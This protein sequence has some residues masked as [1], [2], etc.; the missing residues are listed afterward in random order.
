MQYTKQTRYEI[1][2]YNPALNTSWF[3]EKLC[4]TIRLPVKYQE[5]N[6]LQLTAF[7]VLIYETLFC[8]NSLRI[9]HEKIY[10]DKTSDLKTKPTTTKQTNKK[11]NKEASDKDL[12]LHFAL[13]PMYQ[14]K[15]QKK[16]RNL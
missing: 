4:Y 8:T 13:S 1:I 16:Q 10:P 5:K 11:H 15:V 12:T 14:L 7:F 9:V 6:P 2:K 3:G